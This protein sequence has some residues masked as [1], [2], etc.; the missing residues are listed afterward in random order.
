[1]QCVTEI[2][3]RWSAAECLAHLSISTEMFELFGR[4]N[5]E[6]K[7]VLFVTHDREL[8]ARAHRT[9]EIRDGVVVGG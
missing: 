4:L 5:A 6:G 8:A 2:A 1:M 7:T 3:G 9:V